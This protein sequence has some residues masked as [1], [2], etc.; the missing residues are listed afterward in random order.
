MRRQ[1][2]SIIDD[3]IGK[4]NAKDYDINLKTKGNL[5]ND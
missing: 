3:F 4:D 2:T 5:I 1:E